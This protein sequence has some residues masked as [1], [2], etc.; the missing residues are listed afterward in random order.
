MDRVS[1]IVRSRI[2]GSVGSSHT[3]PEMI[4]R[5]ALHA[6]GL[7]YRLHSKQLPG[8]PDIV[9]SSRNLVVFVHGCFWHGCRRCQRK[10]KARS[11]LDYWLPKIARNRARDRAN[12]NKLRRAG[13]KVLAIWECE[14][15][16]P[17]AL[18]AFVKRVARTPVL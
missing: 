15:R 1:T 4:V 8:K 18:T 6:A 9:L 12:E 14:T 5:R 10:K 7:R 3:K 17:K 2:M 11:N 16:S 13:W